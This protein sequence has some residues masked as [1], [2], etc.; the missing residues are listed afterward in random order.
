MRRR[1]IIEAETEILRRDKF[2]NTKHFNNLRFLPCRLQAVYLFCL[3]IFLM[4]TSFNQVMMPFPCFAFLC[5]FDEKW[6][7][8][9]VRTAR[10]PDQTTLVF[11][12]VVKKV[13]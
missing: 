1:E 7:G 3:C 12:E 9:R 6:G 10:S 8:R 13:V 11:R 2:R 5:Y 4:S